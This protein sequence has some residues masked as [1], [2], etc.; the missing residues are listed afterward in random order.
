LNHHVPLKFLPLEISRLAESTDVAKPWFEI[1]VDD[2][3][4]HDERS[5]QY[6]I[7]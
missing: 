3:M 1:L 4:K 5:W 2:V 7:D 6:D